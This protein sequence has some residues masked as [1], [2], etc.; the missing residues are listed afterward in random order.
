[1]DSTAI[2]QLRTAITT[3]P[4]NGSVGLAD[5]IL[6]ICQEHNLSLDWEQGKCRVRRSGAT[7]ETVIETPMETSHFRAILARLAALC[8]ETAPGSVT[9]Y[10][11]TTQFITSGESMGNFLIA[12]TNT[13][14][15]QKLTLAAIPRLLDQ[16][17]PGY[18]TQR[19]VREDFGR[20]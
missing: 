20:A 16:P 6:T 19:G 4:V 2:D 8:N 14:D 15:E 11:G 17:K 5:T 7:E 13:P 1:M 10:G 9:P 3:P 18:W 12:F